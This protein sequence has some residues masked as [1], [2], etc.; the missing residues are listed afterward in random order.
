M[1]DYL[2]ALGDDVQFKILNFTS[3][4][5]VLK[6][7]REL[8]F[9]CGMA[10]WPPADVILDL[11]AKLAENP[12]LEGFHVEWAGEGKKRIAAADCHLIL[13]ATTKSTRPWRN[14]TDSTISK[15]W[16]PTNAV[17]P[18]FLTNSLPFE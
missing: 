10:G 6:I 11:K 13:R 14:E 9:T 12:L 8:N 3:P 1:K 2:L 15:P 17:S 4:S 5:N 16:R 7:S 18:P